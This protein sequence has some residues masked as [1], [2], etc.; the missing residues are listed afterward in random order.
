MQPVWQ[1]WMP[2][3]PANCFR[4]FLGVL[5]PAAMPQ[6]AMPILTLMPSGGTA[7]LLI[8]RRFFQVF[9]R[10]DFHFSASFSFIRIVQNFF[11]FIGC[12]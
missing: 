6:E 4:R 2:L 11:D 12:R 3:F 5:A 1:I 7:L 10:L 9:Y 8:A